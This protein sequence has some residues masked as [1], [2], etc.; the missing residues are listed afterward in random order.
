MEVSKTFFPNDLLLLFP[1]LFEKKNRYSF[2]IRGIIT[3]LIFFIFS[4]YAHFF[5]AFDLLLVR[6]ILF[7]ESSPSKLLF[8]V[9]LHNLYSP[10]RAVKK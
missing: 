9:F 2:R 5:P 10:P 7:Y 4:L 1:L 6:K 3:R 8:L